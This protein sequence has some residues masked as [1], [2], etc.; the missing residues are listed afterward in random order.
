MLEIRQRLASKPALIVFL[1]FGERRNGVYETLR[2]IRDDYTISTIIPNLLEPPSRAID[3]PL[4]L[5]TWRRN[6]ILLLSNDDI[7]NVADGRH[8][9]SDT[10]P[11]LSRY[12]EVMLKRP[13]ITR[14]T[15]APDDDQ[16]AIKIIKG[17]N[18]IHGRAILSTRERRHSFW[19]KAISENVFRT[20]DALIS[21]QGALAVDHSPSGIGMDVD[22]DLFAHLETLHDNTAGDD[23][24]LEV[25]VRHL[26]TLLERHKPVWALC[27]KMI[28]ETPG[29]LR[30]RTLCDLLMRFA[31]WAD[32]KMGATLAS[33]LQSHLDRHERQKCAEK[34]IETMLDTL[35]PILSFGRVQDFPDLKRPAAHFGLRGARFASIAQED[36]QAI[37]FTLPEVRDQII[38]ALHDSKDGKDL[39]QLIHLLLCDESLRQHTD[40]TVASNAWDTQI[41]RPY[42]RLVQAIFHGLNALRPNDTRDGWV[43]PRLSGWD[44]IIPSDPDLLWRELYLIHF[45]ET[46]ERPGEWRLARVFANDQLKMELL[47]GFVRP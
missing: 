27:L 9:L 33:H 1:G 3:G 42:R 12:R 26:L 35:S 19:Q 30:S 43:S 45:R 25:S 31:D 10:H 13:K 46:L 37:E 29:G 7:S 40:A 8:A 2:V 18:Y 38:C 47:F 20:I 4:D 24:R 15:D 14:L 23:P 17:H 32:D 11:E 6:R 21:L 44:G 39:A 5:G 28:A 36:L 41:T 16:T 34:E 22:R